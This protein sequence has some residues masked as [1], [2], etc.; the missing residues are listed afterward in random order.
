VIIAK[1]LKDVNACKAGIDEYL[2]SRYR[3]RMAIQNDLPGFAAKGGKARAA[4]LTPSELSAIGRAGA[5]ARWEKKRAENAATGQASG[6]VQ[7]ENRLEKPKTPGR[8]GRAELQQDAPSD[9]TFPV[10]LFPGFLEIGATRLPV[11][12]LDNGKRVI[13]QSEVVRL[14]TDGSTTGMLGRYLDAGNLRP[15][16]NGEHILRQAIRFSIPGTRIQGLGY[17]ATLLLDMCDAYL[18]AREDGVLIKSQRTLA[19]QAEIITRAC[20]KVG[21]I[22]LIDEATGYQEFRKKRELQLK[23]QA[24][25]AEDLQEW[26]LMFPQD[27]WFELARLEGVHYSPRSRPLRWGKYIMAFVYD[28]IDRDIGKELRKKN[29][30]PSHGKNHHQWLKEFG[31]QKVHDQIERVV[32]I[33]KLCDN[34]DEFRQKFARVFKKSAPQLTFD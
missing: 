21:I 5:T 31:R 18:R 34:M 11:Y 20:A 9:G 25:I 14:L 13:T 16:I 30:N 15:Y 26:A 23:L 2:P 6:L 17:E 28:T 32:T 24:F 3:E 19:K 22:A 8:R 7:S 12:V 10:A 33:M 1:P 27:F 29:P 4:V